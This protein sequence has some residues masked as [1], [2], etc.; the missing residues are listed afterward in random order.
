[1]EEDELEA[2]EEEDDVCNRH[3]TCCVSLI[4]LLET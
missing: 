4:I 2:A 3:A 1:M